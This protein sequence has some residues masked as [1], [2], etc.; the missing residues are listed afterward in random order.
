MCDR[1][2]FVSPRPLAAVGARKLPRGTKCVKQ[3]GLWNSKSCQDLAYLPHRGARD[4]F[5]GMRSIRFCALILAFAL[6]ACDDPFA[7]LLNPVAETPGEVMLVDFRTG[8]LQDPS[9]FDLLFQIAVRVDQTS[10]WDFAYVVTDAQH[11]LLPFG[12]LADSLTDAGFVRVQES[13]EGLEE[14]P[15]EG[16]TI[17]DPVTIAEG[18]VLAVRSRND[19]N[20]FIFCRRYAKIEILDIDAELNHVTFRF[21]VNPNCEDRVLVPGQHGEL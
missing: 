3:S 1:S 19:S 6:V 9:A 2:S 16:Y 10:Q 12:A 17:A 4:S 18:D 13:F 21:L 7:A 20:S 5:L 8:A 14:A 15:E 11:Q